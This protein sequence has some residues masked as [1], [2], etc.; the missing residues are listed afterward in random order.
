MER[1]KIA[2]FI[3]AFNEESVISEILSSIDSAYDV[4]VI[5]DG[6][7]DK[8][9]EIAKEMGAK[10]V[11]HSINLGQG[12][13]LLTAFKL[14]TKKDYDIIIEMDGD[15]QHDPKEIPKFVNK[16]IETDV[17]I[18]A[19][20]RILGSSYKDAPFARKVF[21]KPLTWLLNRLSGYNISDS[22][23]GFRAFR[24]KAL[25]KVRHLFD[26]MIEP[27]YIASEMWIKFAKAGLTV[28]NVPITLSGRKHGSSYKGLFRYAWG[29]ISTIIRAKLDT[30]K[31]RYGNNKTSG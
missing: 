5:D 19:G 12:M 3:T 22:M 10:V 2:V 29:V 1:T 25:K 6:S 21:L 7:T 30:Y 9:P 24:G 14:L 31:Y 13:T 11:S 26:D 18:L 8:T 17:D 27:E 20:S 28:V 15:G 23:C 16:M 4:F